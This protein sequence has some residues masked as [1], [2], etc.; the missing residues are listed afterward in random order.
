MFS[1]SSTKKPTCITAASDGEVHASH[2][3][4]MLLFLAVIA[5]PVLAE[6]NQRWE[7]G[8]DQI[9]ESNRSTYANLKDA[10]AV[11]ERGQVLQQQRKFNLAEANY[12]KSIATTE[13]SVGKHDPIL[14]TYLRQLGNLYFQMARF[15]QS[16]DQFRRAQHLIHRHQGVYSPQQLADVEAMIRIYLQTRQLS[17]ADTQQHFFYQIVTNHY[18]P[19]DHRLIHAANKLANW[20]IETGQ[21]RDAIATHEQVLQIGKAVH[22]FDSQIDALQT[23]SITDYLNNSCCPED[24][25]K[26]ALNLVRQNPANNQGDEIPLLMKLGDL[27]IATDRDDAARQTYREAH[28][29]S[30]KTATRMNLIEQAGPELLPLIKPRKLV[31]AMQKAMRGS[32]YQPRLTETY[33][34][35]AAESM[36]GSKKRQNHFQVVGSPLPLCANVVSDL[37]NAHHIEDIEHTVI[38]LDFTV[39]AQGKTSE[40]KLIANNGTRKLSQY[41]IAVLE[42]V[43]YRPQLIKGKAVPTQHVRLRQEFFDNRALEYN[44]NAPD[45]FRVSAMAACGSWQ[46][47]GRST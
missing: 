31:S 18:P 9:A 13:R 34:A 3:I 14:I 36:L 2:I 15:D 19:N 27:Y 30:L 43:R 5:S 17:K 38:D 39:N 37:A 23:L 4:C 32:H 1:I 40:I 16:M 10:Q 26:Q 20:L 12:R 29:V 21:F 42:A 8:N 7:T 28:S 46:M 33:Y 44:N 35:P 45:T 47:S 25:L 11:F 22:D 24:R 41:V 6:S